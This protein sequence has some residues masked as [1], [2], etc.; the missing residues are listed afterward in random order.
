MYAPSSLSPSLSSGRLKLFGLVVLWSL[1]GW[2]QVPAAVTR[3]PYLQLSTEESVV[4]VWRSDEATA[5]V[6]RYGPSPSKLDQQEAKDFALKVSA[7]I[8]ITTTG[9]R[10][11]RLHSA[12]NGTRQYE[13][14]LSDL[15][16]DTRYYYAIYDG[17]EKLAGGDADHFF[18]THPERGTDAPIRIWA[19]GDSGKGNEVQ[20]GVYHGALKV[21]E[22]DG[23]P[24]NMYLHVGDMAYTHGRDLEFQTGFFDMYQTTL[25]HAV[26]WPSMGNHEGHTSDGL[27]QTGPYYD[28]YV[29]PARGEA[30]GV[31]SGTEAY[32]SFDYGRAHFICLNSF[33]V[34]RSAEADMAQWLKADLNAT[35]ADWLVVFFHHP[36]Y[37]KGSHD[38]DREIELI[39]MREQ[40]MPI[41]EAGGVDM[42]L[43]GHSHIYERSMLIDGA[44]A[45]PTVADGVVLDDG[46]GHMHGD[47]AYQ[48]SAGL[49]AHQGVAQLVIGHGGQNLSR[50][51]AMPI[52]RRV[53]MEHGSMIIDIEGDTLT[54]RMINSAGK[55]TD[56]FN[57]VKR[58]KVNPQI[59]D[60]PWT[61]VG[62]TVQPSG[63]EVT[64]AFELTLTPSKFWLD[65]TM[66]YT[67]DGSE[68]TM[69]S[70]RYDRPVRMSALKKAL[71]IRARSYKGEE[72]DPSLDTVVKLF[73]EGGAPEKK[74]KKPAEPTPKY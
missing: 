26:C 29:S 30:G 3:G 42:V 47:G 38:S 69:D 36:P 14:K 52:M 63:G 51:G 61:P 71:T 23:K 15:E 59:V 40:I 50:K 24:L 7:G 1:V 45:T 74:A 2:T 12:P 4:V 22:E 37:T 64:G 31:V 17:E 8:E 25:R 53:Q 13:M 28:A 72:I 66:R 46:D 60:N 49:H 57:I 56:T 48:K 11:A 34:D 58:G 19:V 32:Y 6:V 65:G 27:I 16:P 33:D 44:Y 9:K 54:S 10:Y 21:L 68:P 20:R 43:T 70:A 41:L 67:L 5:P 18:R 62:P 35:N 55:T 73:P 39:E